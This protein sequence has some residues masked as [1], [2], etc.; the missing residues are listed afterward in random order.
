MCTP[1]WTPMIRLTIQP[2]SSRVSI[3]IWHLEVFARIFS[4]IDV[5]LIMEECKF[6]K[7]DYYLEDNSM[8][9]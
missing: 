8:T 1:H 3:S 9:M 6:H 7:L 2:S 5:V 4:L